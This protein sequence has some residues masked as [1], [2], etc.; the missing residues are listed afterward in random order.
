MIEDKIQAECV[1]WFTNNYCLR[2]HTPKCVIFSVPNGGLRN[3]IEAMK[4][5]TTGMKAGVSD[6]V[7]LIPGR[8]LF[9]EV[10]TD[11]GRQSKEQIDFEADVVAL[12][13][14]YFLIRS[15]DEFKAIFI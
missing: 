11:I 2:H 6:L 9:V 14:Q 13:F 3:K 7:V 8:A 5:V 10:K 12:G 4:L 1:K 15:I